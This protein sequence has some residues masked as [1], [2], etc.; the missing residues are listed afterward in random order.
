MKNL[1]VVTKI[2]WNN[3]TNKSNIKFIIINVQIDQW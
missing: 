1:S 2:S 3:K